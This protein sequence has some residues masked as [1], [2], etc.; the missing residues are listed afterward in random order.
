MS[1]DTG[2]S[3]AVPQLR[4]LGCSCTANDAAG[5]RNQVYGQVYVGVGGVTRSNRYRLL[6]LATG[7]H[8]AA[9]PH[10]CDPLP[11]ATAPRPLQPQPAT[12][13]A[14]RALFR[15]DAH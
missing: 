15:R 2:L 5:P 14:H 4:L 8:T 6:R 11:L 13:T 9:E 7:P 10:S 1:L 3:S 12:A